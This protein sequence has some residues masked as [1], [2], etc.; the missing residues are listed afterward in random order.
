M[1]AEGHPPKRILLVDDEEDVVK[2]VGGR[3]TQWGYQVVVAV[4]GQEA[5]EVVRRQPPDLILLDLR[6]PVLNGR[7]VCRQLKADPAFARIPVIL[8]TSSSE[9]AAAE[10]LRAIQADDC[11]LKPFEL[12]ELL[13][14]IRKWIG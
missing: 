7:E 13:A 8:M 11:V 5:L 4:N 3:L 12:Q 1:S 9:V 6:M 10:D 14:T 2:V